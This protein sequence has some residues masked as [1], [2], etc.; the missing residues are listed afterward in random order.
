[1]SGSVPTHVGI[2]LD[3]NRRW[4]K[5]HGLKTVDGHK[6]GAETFK[7]ISLAAFD[8]GVQYLTAFVFSTENWYRAK[9]EVSFLMKLIVRAVEL[10]LDEFHKKNIKI[11]VVGSRDHV[12]D[13]AL[14]A[15]ER[16]EAKTAGNTGGV[17]GL[18]FNYGGKP[19]L[20]DAI[21]TIVAS[22]VG[23]HEVDDELIDSYLYRPEIPSMDLMIR[24]SGEHRTS[25]FMMWRADYA[26]L[27]FSDK[28][29]P[30]FTVDD[31]DAALNDY[32]SRQ[33]RFGK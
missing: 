13:A 15:I 31:F 26:E 14:K 20:V 30:D 12:P 28:L 6:E 32:A 4:A 18:C 27:Y 3:G 23:P 5:A 25:G 7:K 16:T 29:W 24:T 21:R 2:I 22:G 1:M 11:V 8:R 9:D 33:R 10:H 19:E 17:L